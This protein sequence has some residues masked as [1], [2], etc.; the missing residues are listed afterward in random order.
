MLVH[1]HLN[2]FASLQR[3]VSSLEFELVDAEV[4]A[5]TNVL[6]RVSFLEGVSMR[7][8]RALFI[9]LKAALSMCERRGIAL[10]RGVSVRRHRYFVAD[11]PS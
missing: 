9:E 7:Q 10:V 4:L 11:E 5:V 1:L 6:L 2:R 3:T 8:Q